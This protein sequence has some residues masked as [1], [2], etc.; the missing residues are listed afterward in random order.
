MRQRHVADAHLVIVAQ[1][2][3]RIFD[4]VAAFDAKQ[5]G[6]FVLTMS[7]FDIGGRQREREILRVA[8][9]NIG[10]NGVDH[11]QCAVGGVVPFHVL[12]RNVHREEDGAYAA[13]LEARN[14]SVVLRRVADIGAI[15]SEAGD[16]VMGVDENGGSGD[17]FD[18]CVDFVGGEC[19]QRE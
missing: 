17:R 6:D 7:A 2:T 8:V 1:Q 13:L 9:K 3:W 10:V 16:V 11:L 19:R 12:G 4:G 14:I 5:A 18:L 15:N